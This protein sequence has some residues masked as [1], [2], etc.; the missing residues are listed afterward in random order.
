MKQDFLNEINQD[1]FEFVGVKEKE[2]VFGT[3]PIGF[4]RDV[5]K[6]FFKRKT[7]IVALSI[8][9]L[10]L[11]Y[12]L[13][14]PLFYPFDATMAEPDY[15]FAKPRNFL[16]NGSYS[17]TI[18]LNEF[19]L[20]RSIGISVLDVDGEYGKELITWEQADSSDFQPILK[21]EDTV[22]EGFGE[23]SHQNGKKVRIDSYLEV[24]FVYKTISTDEYLQILEWEQNN[25][26]NV[27]YPM[28]DRYSWFFD[29]FQ[30]D[31]RQ[32]PPEYT[33]N[34]NYWFEI[35]S[36]SRTPVKFDDDSLQANYLVFNQD[37]QSISDKDKIIHNA[38]N[39]SIPNKG[40]ILKYQISDNNVTVRVLSYNYFIYRNGTVPA[41]WMGLNDQGQDIFTR[42][43]S[44]LRMSLL[45]AFLVAIISMV[46]GVLVGAVCG[47]YGGT[48][49]LIV[50]R[51]QDVLVGVPTIVVVSLI[52]LHFV[53][54]G[55]IP[56]FVGLILGFVLFA[57]VGYARLVRTQFFRF[58]QQEYV[59][60]SKTLGAKNKRLMFKHI[61]PNTLGTLI[62]QF[63]LAIPVTI[64]MEVVLYFLNILQLGN[65]GATL[66]IL[67]NEGA[68]AMSSQPHIIFWPVAVFALIMLSFNMLGNSLRDAF[69]PNQRGK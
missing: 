44:G 47:F 55:K 53:L 26:K 27:I 35:S 66:G 8:I 43:A 52:Y 3:K 11:I 22:L 63:A 58:K 13:I 12:S 36:W 46:L 25:G 49:D 56:I 48:V 24:G 5:F 20:L 17:K 64:L 6:R 60:A 10:L 42:L 68:V 41:F 59:L 67:I 54:T 33:Q 14:M 37:E 18:G 19:D 16:S 34:A 50:N 32:R 51:V 31:F 28:V 1:S 57:W 61:F 4:Y 9:G 21:S 65:G 38:L 29:D 2:A 40:D 15:R 30:N 7:A 45:L 23:S 39:G 62:T 69:D